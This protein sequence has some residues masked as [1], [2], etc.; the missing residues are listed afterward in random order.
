LAAV[1]LVCLAV[2]VP[3]VVVRD[4]PPAPSATA[5]L[6]RIVVVAAPGERLSSPRFAETAEVAW[7]GT[8]E[9]P[10][11]RLPQSD[12]LAKNTVRVFYAYPSD[13]SDR[14]A[15][16]ADSIVT[17]IAAVDAWWRTQDSRVLR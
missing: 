14:F 8:E 12:P 9:T 6:G 3:L 5:S 10:T 13:V 16:L 17:D 15:T 7:C 4:A 11:N 2:F 1:W